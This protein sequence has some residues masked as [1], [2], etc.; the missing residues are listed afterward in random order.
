[1]NSNFVADF[2]NN[3][4][5]K[6]LSGDV[7][8]NPLA[9]FSKIYRISLSDLFSQDEFHTICTYESYYCRAGRGTIFLVSERDESGRDGEISEGYNL[10]IQPNSEQS[11]SS[12]VFDTSELYRLKNA[13]E[14][15][16]DLTEDVVDFMKSIMETPEGLG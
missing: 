1:M 6:T 7:I 10:Y 8:W 2:V 15:K 12:V 16:S 3:L 13:I 14:L 4:I 11:I 5:K 9:Q